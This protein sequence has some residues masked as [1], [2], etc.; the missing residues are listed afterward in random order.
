MSDMECFKHQMKLKNTKIEE[1]EVNLTI[2]NMKI[3]YAINRLKIYKNM[4]DLVDL[5]KRLGWDE[6]KEN[7]EKRDP[8]PNGRYYESI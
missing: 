6:D 5:A 4:P 2:A 8:M 7:Q 3:N 1:L